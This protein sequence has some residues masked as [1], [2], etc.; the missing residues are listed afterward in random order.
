M[1]ITEFEIIDHGVENEQYFQGCGTC[2][3]RFEHVATGIGDSPYQA[4]EDALDFAAQA[5][6]NE[7]ELV[8]NTLSDEGQ[9]P[10]LEEDDAD[11]IYHYVSIRYN[12]SATS[13]PHSVTR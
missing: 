11:G 13:C 2:F 6:H 1:K 9:I 7:Q 12:V 5:G 4:L 8:I 3:T 10:P